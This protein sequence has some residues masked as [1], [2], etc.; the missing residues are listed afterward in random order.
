MLVLL[1]IPSLRCRLDVL[2]VLQALPAGGREAEQGG[3][4]L[5]G[6][7]RLLEDVHGRVLLLLLAVV[8]VHLLEHDAVLLQLLRGEAGQDDIPGVG[9]DDR[10]VRGPED[11]A[12]VQILHHLAE[13]PAL[14]VRQG[15]EVPTVEYSIFLFSSHG[16]FL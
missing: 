9:R 11:A 4:L 6:D 1:F 14:G 5:H 13:Y 7:L 12:L 2:L 16:F 10:H 15:L 8:L 3:R